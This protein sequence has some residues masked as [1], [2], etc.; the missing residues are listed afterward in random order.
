MV[1]SSTQCF[2]SSQLCWLNFLFNFHFNFLL[3]FF[4]ELQ[5][6]FAGLG[7]IEGA[8][9]VAGRSDTALFLDA[10]HLHAHVLGLDDNHYPQWFE[11]CLYALAYL[12]RHALLNLEA[13]REAV[14]HAGYFAQACH[15]SVGDVRHMHLTIE[16]EHVMFAK[17]IE[18]DVTH[19]DHLPVV[20]VELGRV[21]YRHRVLLIATGEEGHCPRHASWGLEQAFAL[22]ILAKDIEYGADMLRDL[23]L[24]RCQ[25]VLILFFH[26]TILRLSYFSR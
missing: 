23:L 20:L 26:F 13:V 8:A 9:E 4:D 24:S 17:G 16:G 15:L 6:L 21:E 1:S 2:T 18:I 11:G 12:L 22:R 25:L 14:H 19:D 10:A 7:L 5:E 3:S